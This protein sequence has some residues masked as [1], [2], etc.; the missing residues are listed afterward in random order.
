MIGVHP[1]CGCTPVSE[2]ASVSTHQSYVG[3][4]SSREVEFGSQA[5]TLGTSVLPFFGR[6]VAAIQEVAPGVFECLLILWRLIHA[7]SPG[8]SLGTLHGLLRPA[9]FTPASAR[10]QPVHGGCRVPARGRH[11]EQRASHVGMRFHRTSLEFL[12]EIFAQRRRGGQTEHR[13]NMLLLQSESGQ[14]LHHAALLVTR[15]KTTPHDRTPSFPQAS[16]LVW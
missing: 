2:R 7:H 3:V 5:G 1:R 12:A 16:V 9:L 14:R 10:L 4:S 6:A 11:L 13:S 8:I 15:L